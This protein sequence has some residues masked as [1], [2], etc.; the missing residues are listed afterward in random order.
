MSSVKKDV[1]WFQDCSNQY[2]PQVG[3]KNAN[4][5][6]MIQI[7]LRV[8]PGFA[9]TTHAFDIFLPPLKISFSFRPGR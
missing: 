2:H 9:V 6:E 8:P 1:I 5:G 4:L 7:G 3:G